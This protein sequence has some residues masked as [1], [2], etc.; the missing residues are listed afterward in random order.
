MHN[1]SPR[2]PLVLALALAF[3]LPGRAMARFPQDPTQPSV[4]LDR[5][6]LSYA[7]ANAEIYVKGPN[8][9]PIDKP[10][11]VILLRTGGQL[12]A[13]DVTKAGFV[14]FERVPYSEFT[15][16]IIEPGYQ[17]V[18]KQFEVDGPGAVTVTL[19]LEPWKQK[20]PL[21]RSD[22]TPSRRKCKRTRQKR[23]RLCVR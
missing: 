16:Q 17:P 4:A 13:K 14:K 1:P 10:V 18:T 15:A 7:S 9:A 23:W 8:G 3:L 12:Y 19:N 21:L 5:M 2:Y 6:E 22:S 11:T 20:P